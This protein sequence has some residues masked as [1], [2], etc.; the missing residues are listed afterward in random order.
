MCN[1]LTGEIESGDALLERANFLLVLAPYLN[2]VERTELARRVFGAEG[3]LTDDGYTA[4]CLCGI[5]VDVSAAN[6]GSYVLID[7]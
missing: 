4:L 1:I 6:E 3:Q 2:D 5:E 7:G